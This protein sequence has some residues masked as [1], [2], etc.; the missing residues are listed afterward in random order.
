M[1][2]SW[3]DEMTIREGV[4]RL[5]H[6]GEEH[7]HRGGGGGGER[8]SGTISDLGKTSQEKKEPSG[9]KNHTFWRDRRRPTARKR[10]EASISSSATV[11]TRLFWERSEEKGCNRSS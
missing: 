1:N 4:T 5:L 3:P 8:S 11:F 2:W 6:F 7:A 9:G 10:L